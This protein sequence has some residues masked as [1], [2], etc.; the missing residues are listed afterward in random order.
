L[1]EDD[2]DRRCEF[3]SI[4]LNMLA[5][6]SSLL[7]RIVWTDEAIFKLNGHVNR[8]NC[9][10]YATENPHAIITQEMNT[11][12][13]TVWAGIWLGGIIGPFFFHNNVNAIC[14]TERRLNTPK[15][16]DTIWTKHFLIDGSVDVDGLI[17][18]HN[19]QTSHQLISFYGV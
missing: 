8:H 9:V 11:P 19:H 18:R 3:A 15:L 14:M 7:D 4:I 17:G 16:S 6:D 13:I 12:G 1:N 5:E 2:P 10:H